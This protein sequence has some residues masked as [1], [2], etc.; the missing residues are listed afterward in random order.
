M[1]KKNNRISKQKTQH[2]NKKLD[3]IKKKQTKKKKIYKIL[4]YEKKKK[5][6]KSFF[7]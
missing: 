6:V 1:Y 2:Q 3:K 7:E 4:K 5:N